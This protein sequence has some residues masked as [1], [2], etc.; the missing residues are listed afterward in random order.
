MSF[1]TFFGF[2]LTNNQWFILSLPLIYATTLGLIVSPDK[3]PLIYIIWVTIFGISLIYGRVSELFGLGFAFN[4]FI[5]IVSMFGISILT[6]IIFKKN[7]TSILIEGSGVLF[8]IIFFL[9][10]IIIRINLS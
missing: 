1:L 7:Y 3:T 6:D 8:L 5:G 4:L 10:L 2:E 9:F